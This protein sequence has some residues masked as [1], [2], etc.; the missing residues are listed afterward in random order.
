[1]VTE[2]PR[3][4]LIV[5]ASPQATAV[6]DELIACCGWPAVRQATVQRLHRALLLG[7][8][9]VSLFWLDHERDVAGTAALLEWL[10]MCQPTVRRIAVGFQL[11]ADVEVALRGAGAHLY[12]AAAD[13]MQALVESWIPQ[14]RCTA[15]HY[16]AELTR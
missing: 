13:D 4:G 14:W 9:A 3:Y 2:S 15:R 7:V 8:P 5:S 10:G 12:L 16:V 6:L 11:P 1:M